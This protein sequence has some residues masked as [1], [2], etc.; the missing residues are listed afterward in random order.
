MTCDD[1]GGVET[2]REVS[3][4]DIVRLAPRT[5]R[6]V[7]DEIAF[8]QSAMITLIGNEFISPD[9][10][11][12]ITT[13]KMMAGN[14]AQL[15]TQFLII[16]GTRDDLSAVFEIKHS[17]LQLTPL[18]KRLVGENNRLRISLDDDLWPIQGDM[19]KIDHILIPL[20]VN[21]R[22]AMR[23]G[24]TLCIRARN[25]TKV[26]CEVESKSSDFAADC[27]LIEVA[28]EGTGISKEIMDQLFEPFVTTKGSGCGFGLARVRHTIR[29]LSGHIIC[30]SE[31]GCGT[32]F[33]IFLP[34]H[35]CETAPQAG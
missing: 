34:R 1:S 35:S 15:A 4:H 2:M 21:A 12:K 16:T 32:I 3:A 22:E 24:G 19:E 29:G 9:V 30:H 31:L 25:V 7:C 18:I 23:Q 13:I 33:K 26:Q 10:R 11:D 6:N 20:V 8:L 27:V 17:I 14:V 5:A 28:D